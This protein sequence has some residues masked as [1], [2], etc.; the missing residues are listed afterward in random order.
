[1]KLLK[2]M[3]IGNKDLSRSGK[4]QVALQHYPDVQV[5]VTYTSPFYLVHQGGFFAIPP[6][7]S[8]VLIIEDHDLNQYFYLSTIVDYNVLNGKEQAEVEPLINETK[9]YTPGG[10]PRAITIKNSKGAGLKISNYF[11]DGTEPLHN[12][13]VLET[14]QGSKLSLEDNPNRKQILLRNESGDGITITSTPNAIHSGGSMEL[15]TRGSQRF[16]AGTGEMRFTLTDG[17]DIYIENKSTGKNSGDSSQSGNVNITSK[18]RDINITCEATQETSLNSGNI[19]I[20]TEEGVIQISSG[21]GIKIFAEGN[22]EIK[23]NGSINM[24]AAQHIN[25]KAGGNVDIRSANSSTLIGSA[26]IVTV[27]GGGGLNAGLTGTP[28]NLNSPID[29]SE[30]SLDIGDPIENAYGR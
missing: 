3:V 14:P 29:V 28:L 24:E 15:K 8:E 7:G 12:K 11:N 20:H 30:S 18:N 17:R 23:S 26:G 16:Y 10:S 19:F 5:D 6:M 13:V 2:G 22:V 4:F 21:G 25:L 1:M 9:M 27:G